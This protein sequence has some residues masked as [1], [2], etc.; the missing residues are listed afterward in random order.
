MQI[1]KDLLCTYVLAVYCT[2]SYHLFM[3]VARPRYRNMAMAPNSLGLP[4]K[5][6]REQSESVRP[7]RPPIKTPSMKMQDL[8]A[9]VV[10]I[11]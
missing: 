4:I 11:L 2:L 10:R 8:K 3:W 7:K 1:L 9:M 6:L 5:Q